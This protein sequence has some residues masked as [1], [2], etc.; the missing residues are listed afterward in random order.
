MTDYTIVE[1]SELEWISGPD[2]LESMGAEFR[3]NLGPA[4]KVAAAFECYLVKPLLREPVTGRRMDLAKFRPGYHDVTACYHDS[5]EEGF[6]IDGTFDLAFEGHFAAEHYFWRP[7]GWVHGTI[8][9]DAGATAIFTFEGVR[10]EEMSG[11]VTRVVADYD[12]VGQNL[13]LDRNDPRATGTRGYIPNVAGEFVAKV[14]A[15]TWPGLEPTDVDALGLSGAVMRTLSMD[16]T[17]GA[18]VSLWTL[19][20]GF[21]Q[22]DATTLSTTVQYFLLEGDLAVGDRSLG[23][24]AYIYQPAGAELPPLRSAGGA[25]LF[26]RSDARIA[27]AL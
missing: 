13:A 3:A 8:K 21:E 2:L 14:P 24:H 19:P 16:L 10:P 15:S 23:E 5:V 20:A 6:V 12:Q 7:P 11:P 27:L 26:V 22:R 1:T 4:D 25:L 9:T 18:A 17:T